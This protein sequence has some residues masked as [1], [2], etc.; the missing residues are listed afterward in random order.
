MTLACEAL[1]DTPRQGSLRFLRVGTDSGLGSELCV[2][3]HSGFVIRHDVTD[4]PASSFFSGWADEDRSATG[5]RGVT[6]VTRSVRRESNGVSC[7]RS[8]GLLM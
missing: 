5:L 1:S 6:T 3:G 7:D 8:L 2:A 4:R